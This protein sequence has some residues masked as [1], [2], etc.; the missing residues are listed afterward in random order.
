LK[1]FDLKGV[2]A[3]IKAIVLLL[4]QVR[5]HEIRIAKLEREIK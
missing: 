5:E 4:E 3:D 1:P 2:D